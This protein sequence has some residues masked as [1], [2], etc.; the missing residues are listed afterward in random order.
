M[1]Q[2]SVVA[3]LSLVVGV[4]FSNTTHAE[5]PV[6]ITRLVMRDQVVAIT[7]GSDGLQY[8][9][10]TQDGSVLAANISEDQFAQKHPDLYEQVRPAIAGLATPGVNIWAGM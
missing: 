6:A 1:R 5:E 10:F 2:K 8:S 7:S 3:L 4:F 9:V